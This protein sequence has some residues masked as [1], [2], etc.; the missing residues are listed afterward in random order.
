M[1][2]KTVPAWFGHLTFA[3]AGIPDWSGSSPAVDSRPM[4]L[5]TV[6]PGAAICFF[7]SLLYAQAC[8]KLSDLLARMG[9]KVQARHDEYVF[10]KICSSLDRLW[11]DKIGLFLAAQVDCSQPDIWGSANAVYS[12]LIQD[13]RAQR[14]AQ[15]LAERFDRIVWHGQ[16]RHL[17]APELWE[18]LL[19]DIPADTYQNGAFWATASGWLAFTWFRDF[20]DLTTRLFFDLLHF[21]HS[22]GVYECTG[23]NE[24]RIVDYAVSAVNPYG[25]WNRIY[26]KSHLRPPETRG[27]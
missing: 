16:I 22:R 6:W 10:E 9:D 3:L 7:S 27:R 17:A 5:S 18:K 24:C 11:D 12:G 13:D 26:H 4:V 2:E 8:L 19:I 1:A 25:A 21:F 20:P 15:A 14:I 23:P